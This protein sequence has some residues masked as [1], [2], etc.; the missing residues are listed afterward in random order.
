V[1][2]GNLAP[3]SGTIIF[4]EW[5]QPPLQAGAYE[6]TVTQALSHGQAPAQG[7]TAAPDYINEQHKTVRRFTVRGERFSLDPTELLAVFPP[8]NNNGEYHNVLPHAVFYRR[9]LPWER[10]PELGVD[11]ESWLAVL[12]FEEGEA[13][14]LQNVQVGDL[15]RDPFPH[16]ADAA[17]TNSTLGATTACY[18]DGFAALAAK[19][20]KSLRFELEQG[21]QLSDA[22]QVIDVPVDLFARI[23][24]SG[25][26]LKWLAHVRA[27]SS[28]K[29]AGASPGD[30][31]ENSMVVGNRLPRPN[32]KCIAHLVSLEGLSMFLP[33]DDGRPAAI[34]ANGQT[35]TAVRLVSLASWSFT[36]VD[37]KETFDQYLEQLD[38]DAFQRPA[39]PS[40]GSDAEKAVANA[41]RLG[42][43]ALKHQT[44]VGDTT[45]SW[46]R[47]PLLPLR[48]IAETIVQPPAEDGSGVIS[49]ADQAMRFNPKTG[50][51]DVSYA[52][53]WQLGRL[54]GLQSGIFSVGLYN[55]KRAAGH[56]TAQAVEHLNL[57]V[58]FSALLPQ[59]APHKV[60]AAAMA[61]SPPPN[62]SLAG[63]IIALL[64]AGVTKGKPS[65]VSAAVRPMAAL[66]PRASHHAQIRALVANSAQLAQVHE[67][68]PVPPEVTAWL[69]D[70]VKL[71][72][73]PFGYLVPDE[74]MLPMES[75]RMF[76]L[77]GNWINALIEGA[78]SIGRSSSADLSHDAVLVGKLYEATAAPKLVTGFL[79]RS[80]VVD[81]WPGLEVEAHDAR[82][83]SLTVV[84]MDRLAP[85][86]LLFM[87][88][89][90]I[91]HM[92]IHEPA[93]GLHFGVDL[94]SGKNKQNETNP[95]KKNKDTKDMR[96]ITVPAGAPQDARPGTQ[97]ANP[98][99]F[100]TVNYRDPNAKPEDARVIRIAD[101]A[102]QAQKTVEDNKANNDGDQKRDFTSA[103]F[104]VEL[105]EGVQ[106]VKF[107]RGSKS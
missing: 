58:K 54:L 2:D 25:A 37:P 101:F 6:L 13:P 100:A 1:A 3:T 38:L 105:V 55:W 107:Q 35:A 92:E 57:M 90:E 84:R 71:K 44:R 52:A 59:T 49:A 87:V 79:L 83:N 75:M 50:M 86:L 65:S 97:I 12:L 60:S 32:G 47:G 77:D 68:T 91:D 103:E 27:V 45:V 5:R 82:N 16:S 61:K 14:K 8:N 85:N 18:G 73:V 31:Q 30:T 72:G 23:A 51:A 53:A 66:M 56:K 76:R 43:T 104:A 34:T 11:K 98:K 89:G 39:I 41:F 21:E 28:E 64:R 80:A 24:P 102:Q 95:D 4:T 19:S 99:A 69:K 9:T 10:S 63:V 67:D 48:D 81:G 74:V 42:Y 22:C 94:P 26:D 88:E 7:Q 96:Y 78:C 40:P 93:E 33:G 106:L 62:G 70:L 17:A 36:S 15:M 46:M 29:K 20:G